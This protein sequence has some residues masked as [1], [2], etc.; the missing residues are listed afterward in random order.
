MQLTTCC[1]CCSLK[2]GTIIIGV[3]RIVIAV[4]SLIVI[5]T[6]DIKWETIIGLDKTTAEI[7]FAIY[8]CIT[9]LF[10]TLLVIGSIKKKAFM[11]LPWIVLDMMMTIVLMRC[12]IYNAIVFFIYYVSIYN[13]LTGFFWLILGLVAVAIHLFMWEVVY[14]HFK[15]LR[16]ESRNC[17]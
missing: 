6:T 4:L 16:I 5:F 14:N 7:I 15:E 9:I 12:I 8:C 10:C 2:T 11:M 17:A 1:E 3:L 13:V